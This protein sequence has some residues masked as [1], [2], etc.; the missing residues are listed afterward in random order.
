MGTMSVRGGLEIAHALPGR[1]RL[2]WR[3]EQSPPGDLLSRL[4]AEP[5][6]RQVTYKPA[7]RSLVLEHV[8]GFGPEHLRTIAD[9]YDV[10]VQ[11][12]GL[13]SLPPA[14]P[15][16]EEPTAKAQLLAGDIEALLT[17]GLLVTWVRDLVVSRT[18]RIGTL[19]LIIITATSL[20]QFWQRRG[21][22]LAQ[23]EE[24]ARIADL[25]L[26]TE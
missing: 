23:I 3:G 18:V 25:E 8:N 1:L 15:E 2:R 21:R 22:L 4:R 13:R 17:L 19:I 14:V 20:Y 12:A 6:M 26:L 24:E 16:R 11:E 5:R 9:E 7:S 10:P